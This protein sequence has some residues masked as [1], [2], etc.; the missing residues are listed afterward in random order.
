MTAKYSPIDRLIYIYKDNGE[1]ERT[2]TPEEWRELCEWVENKKAFARFRGRFVFSSGTGWQ[3][4]D[5]ISDALGM[6]VFIRP[7]TD[8]GVRDCNDMME[9]IGHMTDTEKM[10]L[11]GQ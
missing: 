10:A 9:R 7:D 1:R 3:G 6:T 8:L 2:M 4:I 5:Y 11:I